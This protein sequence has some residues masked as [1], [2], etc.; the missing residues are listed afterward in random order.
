MPVNNEILLAWARWLQTGHFEDGE[1][2]GQWIENWSG[3]TVRQGHW[4]SQQQ[5]IDTGLRT[6]GRDVQALKFEAGRYEE[7]GSRKMVAATEDAVRGDRLPLLPPSLDT[8]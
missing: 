1:R 3:E 7:V 6:F 5:L 4:L 8:L 2:L